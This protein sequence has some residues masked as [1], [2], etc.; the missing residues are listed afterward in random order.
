MIG[1]AIA[2]L[3]P[4]VIALVVIVWIAKRVIRARRNVKLGSVGRLC[5]R[6]M[7]MQGVRRN[8]RYNRDGDPVRNHSCPRRKRVITYI[9][10]TR[11]PPNEFSKRYQL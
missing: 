4:W 2:F 11:R 7:P 5:R 3:A 1:V 10:P 9:R 8:R 6:R